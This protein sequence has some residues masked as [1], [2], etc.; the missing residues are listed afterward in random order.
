MNLPRW[1]GGSWHGQSTVAQVAT[2][3]LVSQL[4][5]LTFFRVALMTILLSA[6]FLFNLQ[7]HGSLSTSDR[8][9]VLVYYLCTVTFIFSF[10]YTLALRFVRRH[11]S[12]VRLTYLQ[13]SG[14]TFLAASLVLITGGTSS[15]F[16]FFFSLVIIAG[17]IILFRP[18]SFFLSAL[19]TLVLVLIGLVEVGVIEGLGVLEAYRSVFVEPPEVISTADPNE[20]LL[21]V[22]YNV[23]VNV[24]A[25]FGVSYLA[26]WL[27]EKLRSSALALETERESLDRLKVLHEH[28]VNSIATGLVSID[29]NHRVTFLNEAASQ[30]LGLHQYQDLGLDITTVFRDLRLVLENEAKS[31][32][33]LREES[34]IVLKKRRI[35]LGWTLSPLLDGSGSL[36]GHT[37]M[38]TD[39]TRL[40]DL[41]R[42]M[43]RSEKLA[44]IGELSAAI[45]H[46]I[47]NPLTAISGCVEMLSESPNAGDSDKRLMGI[48]LRETDQLN[49][50][51]SDFLNYSRP[52]PLQMQVFDFDQVVADVV[53]VFRQD[54]NV[55][56]KG[57][58]LS[59]QRI[60]PLH[61]LGDSARMKQVLYNLLANAEQSMDWAGE[62][63]ILL[64]AIMATSR[65]QVELS[66]TD[67][68][69]G[70]E[71]ENLERIF[72]PFFTTKDRGT[73]LGLA[74]IHRVIEDHDGHIQVDSE[75]NKGTTF[76]VSLPLTTTTKIDAKEV[77]R[78]VR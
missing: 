11:Q 53:E 39:V 62:I 41:E 28:I 29:I 72:Q 23:T 26:S 25:F 65:P 69:S 9:Y 60:G 68:G 54:E 35:Y 30:I 63:T 33:V 6:T 15:V 12:L 57:V 16:T 43:R 27:S 3:D 32:Q 44:A 2:R 76:T 67:Q 21:R 45:A 73:G 1:A 5:W 55:I 38:F 22:I 17:A 36:V 47:R 66:V 56:Q 52:S 59:L 51:I 40:R 74:V 42:Q 20:R 77:H 58:T 10:G 37:F 46:E 8:L 70:I 18:G 4:K 71:G 24:F 50:W 14:D 13:L 64:S 48:V 49:Q 19:S 61:V 31:K 7:E 78:A 34:V 75:L